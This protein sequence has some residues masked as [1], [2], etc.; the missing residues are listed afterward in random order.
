MLTD[1]RH[2]TLRERTVILPTHEKTALTF[3]LVINYGGSGH[4]IT[5]GVTTPLAYFYGKAGN[6]HK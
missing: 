1:K 3:G 6:E 2:R 5:P 4:T